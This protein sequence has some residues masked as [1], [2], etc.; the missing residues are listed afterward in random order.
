MAI[1][2]VVTNGGL[3]ASQLAAL[4][5]G[6]NLVPTR[7]GVSDVAGTLDPN[8]DQPTSGQF[9]TAPISSRVVI[10]QNTIKFVL[11]V[12]PNQIPAGTFKIVREVYLYINDDQNNEILFAVGQ[13]TDQIRYNFDQELTLDL[14]LSIINLNLQDNFVFEFTQW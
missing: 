1:L 2:G 12:P 11:T 10:D 3:T 7:F 8:R 9:Y 14:E 5:E 4:N 13:P 6:F